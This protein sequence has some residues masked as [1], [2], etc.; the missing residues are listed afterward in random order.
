LYRVYQENIVWTVF[1]HPL[2]VLLLG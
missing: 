1:H 2:S